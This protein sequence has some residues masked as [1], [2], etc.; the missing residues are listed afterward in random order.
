MESADGCSDFIIIP[1]TINA[2]PLVVAGA[3]QTVCDG[4]AVSLNGAGASTY[5]WDNGVI[6]GVPFIQAVGTTTYTVIGTD[7]NGCQNTDQVDVTVNP[8]PVVNAGLDQTLCVGPMIT[9]S[10]SGANAYVW[11]NG[12][13]D[14]VPFAQGVGTITYTVIGTD[15][16][17]CQ[18]TDQVDVTV[19]PLPVVDAGMDQTMCDGPLVT[20]SG[21]GANSYVWDNGVFDGVP[22]VQGVGTVNYT[23]IGTDLNGCQNT[24]LL[25]TPPSPR[26]RG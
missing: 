11:D 12:V 18:N 7:A 24:C 17:G 13:F 25:Y 1:V 14:G 5:A 8:L 10:A 20:L 6:D 2:L 3:D 19:N 26:D 16:N 15:L 21:S 23:V 9:L 4:V 22:F